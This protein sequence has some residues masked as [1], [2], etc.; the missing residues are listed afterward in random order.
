[1]PHQVPHSRALDRTPLECGKLNKGDHPFRRRPNGSDVG[2]YARPRVQIG[3]DDEMRVTI[4]KWAKFNNR[5]FAA[6]VRALIEA[7]LKTRT[8]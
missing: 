3:F 6:E 4:T 5:S 2:G 1:M 8:R 7:G